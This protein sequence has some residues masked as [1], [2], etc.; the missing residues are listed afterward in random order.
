MTG[1]RWKQEALSC[2]PESFVMEQQVPKAMPPP[3]RT[4]NAVFRPR[5]EH[6]MN[7]NSGIPKLEDPRMG[8][9]SG[10]MSVSGMN[11]GYGGYG[12]AQQT[13]TMQPPMQTLPPQTQPTPVFVQ[14]QYGYSQ[15]TTTMPP[16]S[17]PPMQTLP[18]QTQPTPVVQQY[19]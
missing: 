1:L 8:S 19:G 11:G 2:L 7:V 17:P 3:R 12:Y 14:Q 13:T 6:Q 9:V 18:P 15:Q 5:A 10:P 4:P 16:P